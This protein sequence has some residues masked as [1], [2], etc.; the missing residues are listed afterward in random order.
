MV[1]GPYADRN[2]R[3]YNREVAGICRYA[4]TALTALWSMTEKL[5][6]NVTVCSIGLLRARLCGVTLDLWTQGNKGNQIAETWQ[7]RT[8]GNQSWTL[9]QRCKYPMYK[10]RNTSDCGRLVKGFIGEELSEWVGF[11]TVATHQPE[12]QNLGGP[13]HRTRW[14]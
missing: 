3:F 8:R 11:K 5:L 7:G 10:S 12:S 4:R 9:K 6:W 13:D 14:S 1:P 2:D